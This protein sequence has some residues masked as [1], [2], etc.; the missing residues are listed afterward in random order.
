MTL[1]IPYLPIVLALLAVA[2][3]RNGDGALVS[4]MAWVLFAAGLAALT[5]LE[6]PLSVALGVA[7]LAPFAAVPVSGESHYR[8]RATAFG[9]VAPVAAAI[10][11][12]VC[13]LDATT[14]WGGKL[15]L[16]AATWAA[17]LAAI[18]AFAAAAGVIRRPVSLSVPVALVG[19]IA[20]V[21]IAGTG[22]SSLPNAFYGFSLR[23]DSELLQWVLSPV[24]GFE[25]GARLL[26]AAPAPQVETALYALLGVALVATVVVR[27]Q[28]WVW[29]KRL[30]GAVVLGAGALLAA[31]PSIV[32]GLRLPS[33]DPY[34]D[35]VKRRL[36]AQRGGEQL[37]DLG[38]FSG[39]GNISV[40]TMDIA[41]EI[42]GLAFAGLLALVAFVALHRDG[43]AVTDDHDGSR[44]LMAHG[45]AL[46]WASWF[47]L[48]VIHNG[49]LGAPGIGSPGEWA[50]TGVCLAAT[51]MVVATWERDESKIWSTIRELTPGVVLAMLMVVIGLS[52]RFGAIVGL[53]L[54][55][56]Q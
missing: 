54:G 4:A 47:L 25:S 48:L 5:W 38:K 10:G 44:G 33:A 22:R 2:L 53:S 24:P 31:L 13:M 46:L 52:W 1:V 37:L 7:A 43:D 12:I 30:F 45:V 41:P 14:L 23:S 50:F 3:R 42:V 19:T 6:T 11:A 21:V 36:L 17:L 39:E 51:G 32:A 15:V 34:A 27:L 18:A 28:K 26:V 9:A 56:F 29:A 8:L 49:F 55:V 20:A 35:E 40:A 16:F